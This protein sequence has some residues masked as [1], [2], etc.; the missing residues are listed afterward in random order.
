MASALLAGVFS[1]RVGRKRLIY[2]SGALQTLTVI[3][4]MV[5][6][7]FELAIII[8]FIFGLGYGAYQS[9]DWAIATDVLP[10]LDD[11]AKDMGIWHATGTL[12]QVL[13]TPLAGFL[14]DHF[15]GV[16]YSVGLPHLGYTV[17]SAMAAVFFMLGAVLM[18]QV[19][20]VR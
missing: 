12:P 17:I 6:T 18:Y 2:L 5:F 16:G 3:L 4:I 7:S 9:V 14:L 15:Q 8:A 10:S 13:A 19:R 1:D 20:G 11:Y